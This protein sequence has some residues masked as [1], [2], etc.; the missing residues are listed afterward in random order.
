MGHMRHH[1]IIVTG[2]MDGALDKAHD[3]AVRLFAWVSPRCPDQTNGYRSFFIPPDGSKEGWDESESGDS[4]RNAFVAFLQSLRYEDGSSPVDWVE[5]VFGDDGD[6][7]EVTRE[8]NKD[9]T[10]EPET[11]A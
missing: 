2:C 6:W 7:T 8:V 1:S 9:T 5:V 11:D 3:E 10:K 4:H